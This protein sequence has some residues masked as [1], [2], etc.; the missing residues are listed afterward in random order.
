M[1]KEVKKIK[2]VIFDV[3]G[4]LQIP[5]SF[6]RLIDDS[7]LIGVPKHCGHR[8]KSVHE[9]L[10]KKF[11]ILLDQWFDSI[12]TA[13][14]KSIEG[15]ISE[16]Q[17]IKTI[18]KNLKTSPKKFKKFA[19]KAY[20]RNF[21][22]NRQLLKQALELKKLG[23]KIAILSDQWHL[24]KKALIPKFLSKYFFPV[25]VSCDVGMRKPNPKIYKLILKKLNLQSK[26]TLFIDNQIWNLRPAKK[27][28]M[29][30]ILFKD[31]KQLFS[32]KN[33][34]ELFEKNNLK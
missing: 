6:V 23:Y 20:K 1:K 24:S 8:N 32:D 31:N 27:I 3:G 16:E 30:T 18:S 2:A 22:L 25:I 9:Y 33:W 17:A 5:K 7:H 28:G 19:I 11:R 14:A 4:V 10:A 15:I 12:D 21:I 26:Q 13:Y 34:K 29:K